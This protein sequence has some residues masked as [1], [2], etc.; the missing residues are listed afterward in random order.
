M[1]RARVRGMGEAG[2][3]TVV[4]CFS[5][6]LFLHWRVGGK[7]IACAPLDDVLTA[8]IRLIRYRFGGVDYNCWI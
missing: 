5:A 1:F 3:G 2:Q 8:Q 6:A 7:K 4:V